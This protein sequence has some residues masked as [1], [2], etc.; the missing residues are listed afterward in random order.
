MHHKEKIILVAGDNEPGIPSRPSRN[1]CGLQVIASTYPASLDGNWKETTV[2]GV[3]KINQRYYCLTVAHAF[4]LDASVA[5][6][7][8]SGSSTDSDNGL[9]EPYDFY[10]ASDRKSSVSVIGCP[11]HMIEGLKLALYL[12]HAATITNAQN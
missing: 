4:H 5:G 3:L 9:D 10:S 11:P 6:D 12:D 2:G 8:G 7:S 1:L